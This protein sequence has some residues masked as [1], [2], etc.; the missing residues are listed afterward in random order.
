MIYLHEQQ[1]DD[2]LVRHWASDSE[3]GGEATHYLRQVETGILYSEAVD[4][5]PCR[6]TYEATET[7]IE[8]ETSDEAT[9]PDYL[10][11]LAELGVTA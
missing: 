2:R 4:V 5:I 11:A 8:E 9:E 7:P 1:L 3:T 6:Y 10:A